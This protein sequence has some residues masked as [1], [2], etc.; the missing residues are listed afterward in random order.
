MRQTDGR[1]DNPTTSQDPSDISSSYEPNR[2]SAPAGPSARR[3]VRPPARPPAA[4]ARP[5]HSGYRSVINS[6]GRPRLPLIRAQNKRALITLGRDPSLS[7]ARAAAAIT[8]R[9]LTAIR[10]PA[11]S[12][13]V[14]RRKWGEKAKWNF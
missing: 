10:G 3:P 12:G 6:A 4:A 5:P 14:G 9:T 11:D 8:R 7:G 2:R 13:E 1:T